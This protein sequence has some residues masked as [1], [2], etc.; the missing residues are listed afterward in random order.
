MSQAPAVTAAAVTVAAITIS[1]HW[2]LIEV[3]VVFKLVVLDTVGV[4]FGVGFDDDVWSSW[5]SS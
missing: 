5:S 4:G 3:L 2:G 1:M